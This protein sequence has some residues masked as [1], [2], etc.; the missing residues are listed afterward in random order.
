MILAQEVESWIWNWHAVLV[1]IDGAERKVL[2]WCSRLREHVE[3][4]RFTHILEKSDSLLGAVKSYWWS[5][6]TYRDAN[7]SDLQVGADTT[8]DRLHF[9]LNFLRSHCYNEKNIKLI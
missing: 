7:D 9:R 6:R 5:C 1:G 8:D 3:E 4:R 2:G